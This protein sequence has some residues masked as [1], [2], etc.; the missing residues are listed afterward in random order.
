LEIILRLSLSRV[1]QFAEV[2]PDEEI[3]AALRQQ[4]GWTHFKQLIPIDNALKREFHAEMCR[5]EKWNT[6][7]SYCRQ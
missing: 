5:M 7:I 6:R 3:A 1:I 4:L 2:F